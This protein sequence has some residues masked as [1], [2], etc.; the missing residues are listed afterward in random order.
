V[1]VPRSESETAMWEFE[2]DASYQEQLHWVDAFVRE[3][4]EPLD[5][6][7]KA[8][9]LWVTHLGPESGGGSVRSAQD[10][11]GPS[12][13]PRARG[14]TALVQPPTT[15]LSPRSRS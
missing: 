9:G 5:F 14:R 13:A 3:Q 1:G 7:V 12:G 2:T 11:A 4:I 6:E 15:R 8:R 10:H